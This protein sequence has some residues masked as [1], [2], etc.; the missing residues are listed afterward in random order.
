MSK[1]ERRLY[2]RV[3]PLEGTIAIS[4]HTLGPI[5]DIS[6]GGLSFR[7]LDDNTRQNESAHLGIFLGSNDFL[8][9]HIKAKVIR[10]IP[11]KT[12]AIFISTKTRQC[13]IQFVDLDKTQKEQ[14]DFFLNNYTAGKLS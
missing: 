8:I 10:D 5:V 4:H 1:Q 13:S 6:E 2:K 3:S 9:D 11:I 7:Y 14:L 12:E